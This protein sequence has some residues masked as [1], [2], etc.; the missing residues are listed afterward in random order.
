MDK[1][2]DTALTLIQLLS[3]ACDIEINDYHAIDI[4][5]ETI[6]KTKQK[7]AESKC[8]KFRQKI[9][10]NLLDQYKP[11]MDLIDINDIITSTELPNTE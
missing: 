11:G 9:L 2:R 6:K 8:W 1:D 3:N 7:F 4:I 5:I 10:D